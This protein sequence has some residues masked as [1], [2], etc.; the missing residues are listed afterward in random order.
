M[1]PF[2]R[3]AA[4]IGNNNNNR[5]Y[6]HFEPRTTWLTNRVHTAAPRAF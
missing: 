5:H 3:N 6:Y 4:I 1:L 2:K